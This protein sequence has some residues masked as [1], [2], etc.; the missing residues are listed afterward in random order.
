MAF[1]EITYIFSVKQGKNTITRPSTLSSVTIPFER[2]YRDLT[3]VGEQRREQS[4]F[5]GCGWPHNLLIPKGKAGG[6]PFDLFVMISKYDDDK[7]GKF[8]VIIFHTPI[9]FNS[10]YCTGNAILL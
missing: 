1:C 6:M 9:I 5:C 10:C 2:T 4:N 8:L 3:N 7:V